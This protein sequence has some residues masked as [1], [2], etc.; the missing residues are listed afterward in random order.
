M[1][2]RILQIICGVRVKDSKENVL[3]LFGLFGRDLS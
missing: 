3:V 2:V 1:K